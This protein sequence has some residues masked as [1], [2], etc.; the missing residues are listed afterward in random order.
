MNPNDRYSLCR[1]PIVDQYIKKEFKNDVFKVVSN[2]EGPILNVILFSTRNIPVPTLSKV[3]IIITKKFN[4]K[5]VNFILEHMDYETYKLEHS[6][7]ALFNK[8]KGQQPKSI[9]RHVTRF[10]ESLIPK[11]LVQGYVITIAGKLY[12]VR[13]MRKS[14]KQGIVKYTGPYVNNITYYK[15]LNCETPTGTIGV[16]FRLMRPNIQIPGRFIIRQNA[17]SIINEHH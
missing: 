3:K 1:L 6:L 11:G 8:L 9:T 10:A 15:Y 13:H 5:T 12:G 14:L 2:K 16:K 7:S 4:L 17:L